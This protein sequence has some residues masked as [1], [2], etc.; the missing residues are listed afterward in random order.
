MHHQIGLK[1]FGT[2]FSIRS[3]NLECISMLEN[4]FQFFSHPLREGQY[5]ILLE[6]SEIPTGLLPRLYS[7]KIS[8][9][10]ITYDDGPVRWNDYFGKALSSLNYQTGQAVIYSPSIDFMHELA[11]LLLLSLSGK[12]MDLA[13]F[14]KIHACGINMGHKNILISLPSKGGKTTLFLELCKYPEVSLISDDTP[15]ID[16]KGHV[17]AFPLRVGVEAV[18][19]WLQKK[20][21]PLFKREKFSDKF[22][23]PLRDLGRTIYAGKDT[24]SVFLIGLR[25]SGD[26]PRLLRASTLHGFKALFEHM[27][28]GVGLPMVVEYF[29]KNTFRDWLVLIRIFCLRSLA[30]LAFWRRSRVYF[31][32]LSSSPEANAEFLHQRIPE[33]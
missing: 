28:I 9:N 8:Q 12:A 7:K 30:A 21:F 27:V 13:G 22:L 23:I 6:L 15:V 24:S 5:N 32:V 2:T 17:H 1:I 11:Y 4:E 25:S 14:H 33:L 18:P 26:Y 16:S 31:F 19:A 29:V 3:K 10:S 20:D